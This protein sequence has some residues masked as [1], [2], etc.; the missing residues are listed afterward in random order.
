MNGGV[1]PMGAHQKNLIVLAS[2]LLGGCVMDI[3][4]EMTLLPDGDAGTPDALD[5]AET[6][7]PDVE[8]PPFDPPVEDPVVEDPI[9]DPTDT[10]DA[11]D[12]PECDGPEMV[13]YIDRD[14]DGYGDIGGGIEWCAPPDGFVDNHDD[15]YDANPD[16]HPGQT[17]FFTTNRGDGSFDYDCDA[18]PTQQWTQTTSCDWGMCDGEGWSDGIPAC[19]ATGNWRR[20]D[21]WVVWCDV[22][23]AD[24]VQS[25]R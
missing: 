12:M 13:Y 9:D 15:C 25:C 10:T 22:V 24:R 20:C 18:T 2:V 6:V 7:P 1:Y 8:D 17:T 19:G 3:E 23:N 16:A 11:S 21:W 4:G 5:T 14:A